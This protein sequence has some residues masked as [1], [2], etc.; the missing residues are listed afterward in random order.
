MNSTIPLAG[1]IG[2]PISHS[3][4]PRL[5]GHWLAK[6]GIQ[7]HYLPLH[8]A[9]ENLAN[10]LKSMPNMGFVGCNVTIPHKETAL[11][12]AQHVTDA[13]R[14]IGAA[15]TLVFK[16]GE[17]YAD[18][19]DGIGF[20]ENLRQ[21]AP[22]WRA[23]A[24]PVLVIGAGGA[25]RAILVALLDAGA[26]EILLTNRTADR[27]SALAAEFGP[28]VKAHP[29]EKTEALL[30]QTAMVV[31]TTALGMTG[32]DPFPFS[33]SG[34]SSTALATDIVYTPLDTP[35]LQA[36]RAQGCVTVDGLGMLLHQAAPGFARWFGQMPA[37]TEETRRV[38]L[39]Q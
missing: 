6:Y 22:N 28:R 12:L 4:S 32:K 37:V 18:N 38:V 14:R 3:K 31:N 21:N 36:A 39:G 2:F 34:L 25:A 11:A 20:I 9:S 33:L 8:V 29:W 35:F 16:D 19:T 30:P 27:A 26:P 1:V 23:D 15:N 7:G 5:H 10:T 17:I 13:A 24:G